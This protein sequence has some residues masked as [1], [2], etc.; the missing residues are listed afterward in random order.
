MLNVREE[1]LVLFQSLYFFCY[2]AFLCNA[3]ANNFTLSLVL[4]T[5]K[6]LSF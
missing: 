4:T 6:S 5:A 1:N 3:F 2:T